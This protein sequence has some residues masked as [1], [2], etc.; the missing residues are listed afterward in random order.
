[1]NKKT[2]KRR[3]F[4]H[5]KVAKTQMPEL[6]HAPSRVTIADRVLLFRDDYSVLLEEQVVRLRSRHYGPF[7]ACRIQMCVGDI[8]PRRSAP[9]NRVSSLMKALLR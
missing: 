9:S 6:T 1:M 5:H 4:W 2:G 7:E 8:G 3:V